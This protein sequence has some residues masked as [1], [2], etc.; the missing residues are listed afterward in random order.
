MNL[1]SYAIA[2]GMKVGQS[3]TIALSYEEIEEATVNFREDGWETIYSFINHEGTE[4]T[5]TSVNQAKEYGIEHSIS[6]TDE[7]TYIVNLRLVSLGEIEQ[8][9]QDW[10]PHCKKLD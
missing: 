10:L 5:H 8:Y 6:K 7:D 1:V 4:V 2:M 3:L 9:T